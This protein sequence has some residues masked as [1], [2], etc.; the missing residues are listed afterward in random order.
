MNQ[1]YLEVIK[2]NVYWINIIGRIRPIISK[3]VSW[4]LYQLRYLSDTKV[5]LY[6]NRFQ[7]DIKMHQDQLLNL[8]RSVFLHSSL[9]VLDII[10]SSGFDRPRKL[11]SWH[12]D[13]LVYTFDWLLNFPAGQQVVMYFYVSEQDG[14]TFRCYYNDGTEVWLFCH[15]VSGSTMTI[16]FKS[17]FILWI[18]F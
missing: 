4:L 2:R 1:I 13:L 15:Y 11:C 8:F 17:L 3:N 10:L 12:T 14:S 18:V 7:N 6:N 5:K 16:M 9:W